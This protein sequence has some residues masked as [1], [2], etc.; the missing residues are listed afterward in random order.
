MTALQYP[1]PAAEAIVRLLG[2][3]DTVVALSRCEHDHARNAVFLARSHRKVEVKIDN[4]L[5]LIKDGDGIISASSSALSPGVVTPLGR[6]VQ[7]QQV[8]ASWAV[9]DV[10]HVELSPDVNMYDCLLAG[11]KELGLHIVVE[12][13]GVEPDQV[14]VGDVFDVVLSSTA[15]VAVRG[16]LIYGQEWRKK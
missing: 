7:H 12:V 2:T 9:V 14:N 1:G 4:G 10:V 13:Y 8:S 3:K 16:L 15:P 5:C 11:G 6:D